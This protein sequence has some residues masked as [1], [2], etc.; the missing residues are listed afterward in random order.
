M[1]YF[2]KFDGYKRLVLS[3]I[4]CTFPLAAVTPL[5]LYSEINLDYSVINFGIKIQKLIDKAWKCYS[6]LEDNELLNVVLDIKSE[7]EAFTGNKID[8]SKEI[9]KIKNDLKKSGQKPPKGIF[10]KFKEFAKKKG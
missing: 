9:D 3:T 2:Y 8:L 6:N 10:K 4:L 5:Q 7:I 1:G